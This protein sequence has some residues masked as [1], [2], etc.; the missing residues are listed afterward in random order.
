MDRVSPADSYAGVGAGETPESGDRR[1]SGV[2]RFGEHFGIAAGDLRAALR[3]EN[4]AALVATRPLKLTALNKDLPQ[5]ILDG[6]EALKLRLLRT[7]I[8]D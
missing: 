8:D 5:D 7:K 6:L 2:A 4:V 3:P 1:R